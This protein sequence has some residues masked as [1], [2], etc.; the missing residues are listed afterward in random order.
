METILLAGSYNWLWSKRFYKSVKNYPFT[1]S[2]PVE[3]AYEYEIEEDILAETLNC[4]KLFKFIF[5]KPLWEGWRVKDKIY[6]F[7]FSTL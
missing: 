4:I 2:Y 7:A 1:K 3:K 5:I 6:L